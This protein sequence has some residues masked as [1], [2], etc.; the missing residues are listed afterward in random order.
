MS[1]RELSCPW[2]A[3]ME[4]RTQDV[5]KI[6]VWTF[7][8]LLGPVIGSGSIHS[9][10]RV[11][12]SG[13]FCPSEPIKHSM[14]ILPQIVRISQSFY[15]RCLSSGALPLGPY[16]PRSQ[17]SMMVR[18]PFAFSSPLKACF[19]CYPR[20]HTQTLLRQRGAVVV[21]YPQAQLVG[22]RVGGLGA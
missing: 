15:E 3:A 7:E 17:G 11:P 13:F 12:L 14:A 18:V 1:F 2:S 9:H 19:T 6:A 21:L 10:E 22:S 5:K 4:E 8:E 20:V 16:H